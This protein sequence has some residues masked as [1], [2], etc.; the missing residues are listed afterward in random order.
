[1]GGATLKLGQL[2]Q[3]VNLLD[4]ASLFGMTV[5]VLYYILYFIY[6][7]DIYIYTVHAIMYPNQQFLCGMGW[8]Q[9]T[10]GHGAEA[11]M[12]EVTLCPQLSCWEAAAPQQ[13]VRVHFA[14]SD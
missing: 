13:R 9:Q 2:T 11:S 8:I 12:V 6:N 14:S 3:L 1:M 10:D 5:G 4:F 7:N